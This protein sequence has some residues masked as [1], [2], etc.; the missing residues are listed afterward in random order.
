MAGWSITPNGATINANGK[1]TFPPNE[2]G[3]DIVY[4]VKY[5]DDQ[6]CDVTAKVVVKAAEVPPT[7]PEPP[8][9]PEKVKVTFNVR[10]YDGEWYV[11]YE[12]DD[13]V[14]EDP[15]E[16]SEKVRVTFNVRNFS[17]KWYVDYEEDDVVP[18]DPVVT[19]DTGD[20]GSTETYVDLTFN[21]SE[22]EGWW[23]RD[24]MVEITFDV[25]ENDGKWYR[26]G[27]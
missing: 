10:R 17:G 21:V 1:A 22:N 13:V 26:R 3:E 27:D 19:G 6:G 5:V 9:P 12:E 2:T 23:Y 7:P 24:N 16:P 8:G 25:D 18:E 14:P 4:T 20:T 15:P 11:D